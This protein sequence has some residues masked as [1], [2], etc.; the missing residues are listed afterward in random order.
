MKRA[1]TLDDLF[2]LT[3]EQLQCKNPADLYY[4]RQ[5]YHHAIL[6][7]FTNEQHRKTVFDIIAIIRI[8]KDEFTQ[9]QFA[10][11]IHGISKQAILEELRDVS[12][13][14]N[15]GSVE[16]AI[17]YLINEI[18]LARQLLL[19]SEHVNFFP[20]REGDKKLEIDMW[21]EFK[22]AWFENELKYFKELRALGKTRFL[23]QFQSNDKSN[24]L[25]QLTFKLA[26]VKRP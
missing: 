11:L 19:H 17:V 2:H 6:S 4:L 8:E 26:K 24:T 16:E 23:D 3:D 18:R 21:L 15:R 12:D 14:L 20:E 25:I 5:A 9:E 10:A 22:V 7:G 13:E 1:K